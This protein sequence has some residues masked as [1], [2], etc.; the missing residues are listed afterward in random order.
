MQAKLRFSFFLSSFS[1]SIEVSH[2]FPQLNQLKYRIFCDL[3][4][5]GKWLS[6]GETFGGDFLIYPG[7][8][9]YFHASHIVHV[10][11]DD[12]VKQIPINTLIRKQRLSVVVNK[13]CIFAYVSSQTN[14]IIYQTV[15]WEGK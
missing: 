3:Y 11:N 9:L 6:S 10:M 7:E 4:E 12:E 14:E 5:K 15:R 1:D 2:P 8:P 13:F